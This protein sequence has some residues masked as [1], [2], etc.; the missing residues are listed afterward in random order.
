MRR[1]ELIKQDIA[2]WNKTSPDDRI[3]GRLDAW[4]F[5]QSPKPTPEQIEVKRQEL[6][7][8]LP[9]TDEEK[10]EYISRNYPEDPPTDFE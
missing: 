10:W 6:I 8:D 7:D 1:D 2:T 5:T 3:K 4:I 9:Q